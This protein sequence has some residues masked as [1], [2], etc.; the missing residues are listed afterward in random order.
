MSDEQEN[1]QEQLNMLKSKLDHIDIRL[2]LINDMIPKLTRTISAVRS[3]ANMQMEEHEDKIKKFDKQFY[4]LR[5]RL[6]SEIGSRINEELVDI[7][8]H[9]TKEYKDEKGDSN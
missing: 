6:I 7:M 8:K 2:D 4:D 3:F 1:I 9:L 5:L